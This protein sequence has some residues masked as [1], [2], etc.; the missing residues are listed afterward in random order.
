[1]SKILRPDDGIKCRRSF[2]TSHWASHVKW[3]LYL[4]FQ[5]TRIVYHSYVIV[6]LFNFQSSPNVGHA[7]WIHNRNYVMQTEYGNNFQL[8]QTIGDVN[9]ARLHCIT[10]SIWYSAF[11]WRQFANQVFHYALT[12]F[13]VINL[14]VYT[15]YLSVLDHKTDWTTKKVSMDLC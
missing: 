7:N 2:T 3:C 4:G 10:C 15:N 5:D 14:F 1:M 11:S 13:Q 12:L 8:P 6:N 9:I